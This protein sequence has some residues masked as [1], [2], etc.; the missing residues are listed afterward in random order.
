MN[1]HN[2]KVTGGAEVDAANDESSWS[3]PIPVV[4]HTNSSQTH[5]G[6]ANVTATQHPLEPGGFLRVALPVSTGVPQM[7]QGNA[8]PVGASDSSEASLCVVLAATK[9]SSRSG[10]A[11]VTVAVGPLGVLHNDSTAALRAS[12]VT[13]LTYCGVLH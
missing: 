7:Q 8:L 5:P 12:L 6:R 4:Q 13:F 1:Q 10:T 9:S 2:S 11:G 3:R